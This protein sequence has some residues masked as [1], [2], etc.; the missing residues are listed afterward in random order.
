MRTLFFAAAVAAFTAAAPLPSVVFAAA[1]QVRVQAPG[2][3]RY[4][5]GDYE[6]TA[7]LDGVH[8]VSVN[9][10]AVGAKPGE[11][12]RLLDR[13]HLSSPV[14]GSINAFLINTGSRLILIDAGA[15]ELYGKDGGRLF[16]NLAAAGYRPDQIDDIFLTHLHRDHVGGVMLAGQPMFPNATIHASKRDADFWLDNANRA[17]AAPFLGPMF[18]GAQSVLAPYIAA[19]RFKTFDGDQ[20]VSPGIRAI[21][22]PGHTPGH[23]AY[24]VESQGRKLLV[25]GDTIHFAAVQFADPNVA[26]K[27]DSDGAAAIKA[28]ER[29]FAKASAQGYVVAAAHISFPGLGRVR[30]EGGGRFSW[31]PV[32]Y[33]LT[34]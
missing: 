23:T 25:W 21:S 18:D 22:S 7:L 12:S 3:Y 15:G 29:I 33:S 6:I 11:L 32:N 30:D 16:A 17:K 4:S 1:P 14:E 31:V 24:A 26:I 20:E 13:Q 34:H 2:Y 27:Y 10:L 9:D 8:D 28:R 19:G 5:L